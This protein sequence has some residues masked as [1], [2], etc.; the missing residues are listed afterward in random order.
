MCLCEHLGARRDAREAL[1]SRDHHAR[2]RRRASD[3]EPGRLAS[4]F[5]E[6]AQDHFSA[7][8]DDPRREIHRYEPVDSAAGLPSE[9]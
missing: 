9:V 6:A 8:L 5:R 1:S 2:L 7:A 3:T 4:Q